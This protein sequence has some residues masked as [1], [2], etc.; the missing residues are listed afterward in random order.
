MPREAKPVLEANEL[1]KEIVRRI[2]TV[3]DPE[4][5]VLFGSYARGQQTEYSDVDILVIKKSSL[6]R[7]RRAAPIRLA[8]ADLPI[9]K[10][11]LVFTPEEEGEW[12]TASA[13]VLATAIREGKVLYEKQ[14]RRGS[15]L[16]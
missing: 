12:V 11:I 16:D 10:D 1:I 5:V 2:V 4:K 3:A 9:D 8:L 15:G 6:P 13:S 14:Y 7:H